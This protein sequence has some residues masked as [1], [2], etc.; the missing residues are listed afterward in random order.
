MTA[1]LARALVRYVPSAI[2]ATIADVLAFVLAPIA[3][4]PV[5]V[6]VGDDGRERLVWYWQWITTHDQEID[7]ILRHPTAIQEHWLLGRFGRERVLSSPVLRWYARA[8]WIW[9]NPAYYVQWLLGYDMTGVQITKH[10]DGSDTWDTGQPSMS[11]WTAVN[12]RGQTA[13]LWERQIYYTDHRCLE[14]QFGWKL[15]RTQ[16]EDKGR[17]M[18]AFRV[19]P[20]RRYGV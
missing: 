15:Y 17:C 11:Y 13:F 12:A 8:A 5:F 7:L 2:I 14:L 3:A 16:V 4:L 10:V 19:S 9:R 20:F 6:R 18:L 1:G